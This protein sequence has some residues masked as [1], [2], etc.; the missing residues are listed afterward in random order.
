MKKLL[1]S[2]LLILVTVAIYAMTWGGDGGVME[3][4]PAQGE[5][6]SERIAAIDP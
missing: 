1:C 3:I 4:L 2:V 5:A 6:I